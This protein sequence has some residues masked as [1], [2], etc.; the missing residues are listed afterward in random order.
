MIPTQEPALTTTES[1]KNPFSLLVALDEG[2]AAEGDLFLDD[3]EAITITKWVFAYYHYDVVG[4]KGGTIN[5]D[6]T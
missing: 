4:V 5:T 3:G 1:R 2:G 6:Y